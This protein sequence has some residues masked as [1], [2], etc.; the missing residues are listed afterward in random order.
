MVQIAANQSVWQCWRSVAGQYCCGL[1][2]PLSCYRI[3]K[4]RFCFSIFFF[5]PMATS[6][7]ASCIIAVGIQDVWLGTCGIRL[8]TFVDPGQWWG[9]IFFLV[10]SWESRVAPLRVEWAVLF[11]PVPK[12]LINSSR[13]RLRGTWGR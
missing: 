3:K 5:E 7:Y 4:S 8:L 11:L 1:I 13:G 12:R 2:R 9:L 6:C 10:L